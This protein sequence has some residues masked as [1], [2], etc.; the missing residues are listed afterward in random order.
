MQYHLILASKKYRPV[1]LEKLQP[2]VFIGFLLALS[3]TKKDEYFKNYQNHA[4]GLA[5]LFMQF[6]MTHTIDVKQD[7]K[8]AL[9]GLKC[10]AAK[11]HGRKGYSLGEGKD[12]LKFTGHFIIGFWK[13]VQLKQSLDTVF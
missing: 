10:K 5:Q 3:D 8:Q 6:G 11:A 7:M 2:G 1:D 12:P 13:M 4:S 9:A